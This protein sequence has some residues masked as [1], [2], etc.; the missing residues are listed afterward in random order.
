[1]SESRIREDRTYYRKDHIKFIDDM[2]AAGFKIQYYA[3]RFFYHGPAVSVSN[4]QD[5][6]S[7]TKVSVGWDQL[8]MGFIVHPAVGDCSLETGGQEAPKYRTD[9]FKDRY[10]V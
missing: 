6:M 5:V 4:L 10:G 3:G 8:G 9:K 2:E 7:E 1:M